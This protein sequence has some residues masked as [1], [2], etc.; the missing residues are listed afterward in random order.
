MTRSITVT[1]SGEAR[2]VP[3]TATLSIGVEA[4]APGAS[5]ARTLANEAAGRLL[6]AVRA[7]GIDAADIG[8]EGISV[9][10]KY[11]H[12]GNESRLTGYLVSNR[13]RV[14]VRDVQRVG[15]VLDAA[16][17]G[18]GDAG[19]LEDISF[20]FSSPEDLL[21]RARIL[22]VRDARR[23]ALA[24]AA[25]A[26]VELGALLRIDEVADSAPAPR[27]AM[28]LERAAAAATPVEAGEHSVRATVSVKYAIAKTTG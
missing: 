22:A 9:R 17:D 25:G 28:K 3:D 4:V 19:R 18:A 1:G 27:M 6:G 11:D 2:G 24:F 15:E 8:T 7:N 20:G 14:V 12:S 16:L 10:P 21:A 26:G 13:F 5:V 23:R